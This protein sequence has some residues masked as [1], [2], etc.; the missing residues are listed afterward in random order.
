M[1]AP[2]CPYCGRQ[3]ELVTGATIH[4]HRPDLHAKYFWL[5]SPCSAW[6]GTHRGGR[7]HQPLG[8]L[9]NA[10]LR[11]AK[12]AAHA[13]FDPL[14]R[15]CGMRRGGA[16]KWLADQLGIPADKCHIGMFDVSTCERV[17]AVCRARSQKKAE[18]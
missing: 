5:C 8:R 9:A 16:Y 13:A 11:F 10:D 15:R 6:V 7:N 14:W 2:A 1:T 18:T 3:A 4:P 17:V 12:Q